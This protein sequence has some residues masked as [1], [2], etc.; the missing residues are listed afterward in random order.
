MVSQ[1]SLGHLDALGPDG[2]LLLLPAPVQ[3]LDLGQEEDVLALVEE[4]VVVEAQGGLGGGAVTVPVVSLPLP[5]L[6]EHHPLH[7]VHLVEQG[8]RGV[9]QGGVAVLVEGVE[10]R[11]VVEEGQDDG[12]LDI[13]F[14]ESPVLE[15]GVYRGLLVVTPLVGVSLE[16][17]Q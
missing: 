6:A 7:Q 4:T 13:P 2:L 11:P 1:Q 14:G 15:G 12:L 17:F 16:L 8:A 9:A 10:V 3:V 5:W